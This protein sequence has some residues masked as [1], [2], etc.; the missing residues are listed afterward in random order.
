MHIDTSTE[1]NR[2]KTSEL[3]TELF[4]LHLPNKQG[5][6][7]VGKSAVL[8]AIDETDG[9][10]QRDGCWNDATTNTH[11]VWM[12]ACMQYPGCVRVACACIGSRPP[13]PTENEA[14][15]RNR[16]V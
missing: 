10:R 7:G 2:G 5:A 9:K 13:P 14:I 4:W 11:T 3:L 16:H 12:F 1:K 6:C 8:F 15:C